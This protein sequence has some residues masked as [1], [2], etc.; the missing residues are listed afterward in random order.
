MQETA[1]PF[2][3][4]A[5]TLTAKEFTDKGAL[6]RKVATVVDASDGSKYELRIDVEIS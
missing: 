3:A 4:I 1:T 5:A 2:E 6:T